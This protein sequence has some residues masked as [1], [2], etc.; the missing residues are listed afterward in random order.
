M[1]S[2]L[3]TLAVGLVGF[4]STSAQESF[5]NW[6]VEI[7]AS[8]QQQPTWSLTDT[9]LSQSSDS[10]AASIA[11]GGPDVRNS[12]F[13]FDLWPINLGG[14]SQDT[15]G[16][17][18]GVEPGVTSDPFANYL[19]VQWAGASNAFLDDTAC[20]PGGNAAPGLRL[21]R[22]R[23]VPTEDELWQG[24]D[25]DLACSPEGIGLE[26][27]AEAENLGSTPWS[28]MPA[29]FAV[30]LGPCSLRIDVDGVREFDLSGDFENLSG[31]QL[32]AY[33]IS[34]PVF[35]ADYFSGPLANYASFESIGT[36]SMG[37]DRV[38][39]LTTTGCPTDG[40]D[41]E[42][43]LSPS[44]DGVIGLGLL[45]IGGTSATLPLSQYMATLYTLPVAYIPITTAP[46]TPFVQPIQLIPD[47]TLV[48]ED[49]YAQA[50]WID[51]GAAGGAAF[52]NAIR[53]VVG[54]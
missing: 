29:N 41:F 34:L 37:T 19:M 9:L 1:K 3:L 39:E 2:P 48:G 52:S 13:S 20:T 31:T 10:L 53:L 33:S 51:T 27:L 11:F 47:P 17:V 38:P 23:G 12:A 46:G 49:F 5:L 28:G 50:G 4:A 14:G 6:Q 40:G 25:F 24:A 26:L 54:S 44:N 45:A 36:G 42:L 30:E 7:Y 15:G 22:V 32:G 16:F 21:Y 8:P 18:M 35:M 43:Q